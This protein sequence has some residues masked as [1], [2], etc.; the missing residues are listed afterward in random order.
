VGAARS[1][2]WLDGLGWALLAVSAVRFGIVVAG[3]LAWPL[4]LEFETLQLRTVRVIES[5][6]NPYGPETYADLPFVFSV[7]TPLY[8]L[9]VA[10]LPEVAGRPFLVGRLLA[11]SA[12]LAVAASLFVVDGRR[13]KPGLAAFACGWFLL[14]WPVTGHSAYM[15]HEPL[16]LLCSAAALLLL[17]RGGRRAAAGAAVCCLLALGFKQSYVAPLLAGL[18]YLPLARRFGELRVFGGVLVGLGAAGAAAA[19]W[20]WGPGF[21][22]CTTAGTVDVWS[23]AQFALAWAEM[24]R[25]PAFVALLVLAALVALAVARRGAAALK[26]SP[27]PVFVL[28][29]LV[30]LLATVGKVG[31]HTLYF[32]ELILALL[33]GLVFELGRAEPLPRWA[34]LAGVALLALAVQDVATTGARRAILAWPD[35][36]T[37][38]GRAWAAD[39][40]AGLDQRVLEHPL[41]LN[42]GPLRA[43]GS[44]VDDFC[45]NDALLYDRLFRTGRLSPEPLLAAVRRQAFDVVLV[46]SQRPV[47]PPAGADDPMSAVLTAVDESYRLLGRDMVLQYFVRR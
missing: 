46:A 36:V 14:L 47:P 45:V 20:L 5:G 40:R 4:D 9:L 26:E 19:T 43:V 15:R 2:R 28:V 11:L 44:I 42:L 10:A 27:Y 29:A 41:A 34:P 13:T 22:Y 7:Y 25:Q 18:L 35:P 37:E 1:A 24:A 3:Q 33:M 12:M 39:A 32:Y 17:A 23:G 21:W 38:V 8:H 16:G 30:L 31:S 6:L